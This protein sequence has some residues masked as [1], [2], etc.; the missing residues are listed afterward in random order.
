MALWMP[1]PHLPQLFWLNNK[2][3]LSNSKVYQ[4][5]P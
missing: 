1:P 3:N 5:W 2:V 4:D